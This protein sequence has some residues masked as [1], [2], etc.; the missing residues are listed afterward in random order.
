MSLSTCHNFYVVDP[1]L[2]KTTTV[3]SLEPTILHCHAG[4]LEDI[5]LLRPE[6]VGAIIIVNEVAVEEL[7][8]EEELG[9]GER[10]VEL[11]VEAQVAVAGAQPCQGHHA[12]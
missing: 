11:V 1:N 10:L 12:L 6:V 8:A 7:A 3:S 9:E 2:L 4:V 5:A